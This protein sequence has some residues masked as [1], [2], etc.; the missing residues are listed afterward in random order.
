MRP[1]LAFA[2]I[3]WCGTRSGRRSAG[4]FFEKKSAVSRAT[5]ISAK[6]ASTRDLPDSAT[7]VSAS[8]PRDI[9]I[10]W[11]RTQSCAQR[12]SAGKA[13]QV[14]CAARARDKISGSADGSVLSTC[15]W[16]LP[17]AGSIDGIVSTGM[18]VAA[19]TRLYLIFRMRCGF[20]VPQ[21]ARDGLFARLRRA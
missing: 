4:P 14:V 19:I 3:L 10:I 21:P 6:R 1:D 2:A 8:V 15:A 12:D 20:D 7:T 13:L 11:R 17:V 18:A 16:T 9:I 5:K